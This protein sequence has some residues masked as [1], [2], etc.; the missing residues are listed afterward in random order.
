MPK[1]FNVTGV[2]LPGRHYMVNLGN[3][4]A[5]IK[6]LVDDGMYFTIN[7]ARQY[8]KTTT[9]IAL[10]QY[11]RKDYHVVSLDFQMFGSEEFE[12]ENTFALSFAGVFL[13]QIKTELGNI[14]DRLK[15]TLQ[16][17]EIIIEE[18]RKSFRL[19]KL[20]EKI[21]DVCSR[22]DRPVVLMIDETDSAS[23]NQ[24]FI[25]F[26]SQLRAYYIRR[27]T[28]PTFKSVIL[29]GVYDVKN[30]VRKLRPDEA[31]QMNSPWNIAA[32]F[33]VEMSLEKNGIA[34]MLEEYEADYHTGMDTAHMA[35]L[36]YNAT[37]GYPFLVSRLCWLMDK[38]ISAVRGSRSAAWTLDGFM[39]AYRIL[40]SEKNTLFESIIEKVR[41]YP[42]LNNILQDKI[43]NGQTIPYT[44]TNPV[45]DLAAMFGIIKNADGT[46]VPANRIFAKVLSDYYLSLDE[47]KRPDIYKVSRQE[48]T[49][50]TK[51]GKL[52][53]KLV[54]Q[55]FAEHFT[56]LYGHE[57]A[58][59]I[60]KEGRKYFLL[61]LRPIING[62]GH[63]SLE[64][65]TTSENR[66]DLIV[67]YHEEFFIIETKI[68]RGPKRHRE[69]EDQLLGYMDDHHQDTGYL[70]TFNFN[71]TKEPGMKEVHFGKKTLFEA[72]I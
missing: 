71:K 44:A 62:T 68:W 47:L 27:E 39:D 40:T 11:L 35:E 72:M 3:R 4:L 33:G 25:D 14:T 43:F 8:G 18:E 56:D 42:E 34:R 19:L 38:E 55:K 23:N 30:L 26:L 50:F 29:A 2:C 66:T 45:I 46:A 67:Y 6:A 20:F 21:S 22:T 51:G 69:G 61:Y 58:K 24:V 65:V 9:L 37:S 64:A 13:K 57:S 16:Q 1:K 32:D 53:M 48:K 70:I 12:S 15:D 52:N 54:I 10:E 5:K 49:Q 59:F 28:Q 41:D 60:E 17:I 63:Y 7:K 31:H 36:L